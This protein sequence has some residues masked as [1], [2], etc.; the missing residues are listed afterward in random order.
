MAAKSL[1]YQKIREDFPILSTRMNGKPLVFLDSAASSQKPRRV[2]E[3]FEDYYR[4][5]NANI[6]RGA[7]RLSYEATDLY[8][9]TRA[10]L[11][12]FLGA[13]DP[14]T[15][16]F[17]R[18]T[19]ESLNIVAYSWAMNN[20]QPG[21]EI[22]VSELEH[23]SN[24]VPWMMA[25]KK[26]GAILKHIPL[27]EDARYDLDRL[28]EVISERTRI[29]SVAHMSNAV[30]TIH[31]LKTIGRAARQAG[32]LFVVDGAQGACHLNVNVED[33][34]CDFYA[35]SAHKMLGPTGVGALYGKRE[36]LENMEPFLG[37][38]DMILT[39]SRDSFKP[40]P[41][42]MKFEAGTPNIAGVVAF[43]VALDY[44]NQVGLENIHSHEV[45][46]LEYGLEEIKKVEGIKLY[47]SQDLA[48]RGGVISF[49]LDGVHPHDIGSILDEE[50]VAVRAGHHCCEPF[51]KKEGISGTVRAS[52]YLYNGPDDIDALVK[53]LQ[54]VRSI[55]KMP[56]K[57]AQR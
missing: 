48:N 4:C 35:I 8:D 39:V 20:L 7:Y 54:K 42:P 41:L 36:I 32:A 44:L 1:D 14:D 27:T 13:P 16:I 11:A 19:T 43:S 10:R 9:R 24:L 23:H 34:D 53:S 15:V 55:F 6:H 31:D 57:K 21:D 30:G 47:G 18:N 33:L 12:K 40:A 29:V 17:T 26:T 45:A 2:I 46:L 3:A 5:R 22:L 49:L 25:A 38:G 50:G 28:N 51:M 52:F 37:G 56:A